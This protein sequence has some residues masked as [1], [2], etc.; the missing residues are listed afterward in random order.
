MLYSMG[1]WNKSKQVAY[2]PWDERAKKALALAFK[3]LYTFIHLK[4]RDITLWLV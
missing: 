4:R 1:K 3:V 2:L